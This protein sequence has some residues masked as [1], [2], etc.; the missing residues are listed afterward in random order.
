MK[1]ILAADDSITQREFIKAALTAEGF[2]VHLAVDGQEALKEA[3]NDDYDCILLDVVMP[4]ENGFQICRKI[5]SGELTYKI[6]IIMITSKGQDFDKYWGEKQGACDYIVKPYQKSE[7]IDK[8]NKVVF[9]E[10]RPFLQQ[11]VN[12]ISPDDTDTKSDII[13]E[14]KAEIKPAEQ[15]KKEYKSILH[16]L[17][18]IKAK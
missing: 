16:R 12:E 7:L 2:E 5:K 9:G 14:N 15:P 10:K 13:S 11:L 3:E 1:K 17:L 6:P 18:G 8:V 4:G